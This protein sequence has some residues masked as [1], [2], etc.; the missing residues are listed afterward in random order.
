[1]STLLLEG[2]AEF[3]GRMSEPDLQALQLAGGLAAPIAILPTAAAPDH[4][5]ERAGR[6]GWRWFSS[7]GASS[8]DVVPVVD[9]ATAEDPALAARLRSARLIYILGGFPGFLARTLSGS[10]AWQACLDAYAGGAVLAGSSAGA[11]VLCQY[12]YDPE[13]GQTMPGLNL[14]SNACVLPHHNTFGRGWA[15]RL[16]KALPHVLLI[17]IDEQTGM[18]GDPAGSWTVW[19]AGQVTLYRGSEVATLPLRR[20]L[21]AGGQSIASAPPSVLEA[22]SDPPARITDHGTL[23]PIVFCPIMLYKGLPWHLSSGSMRCRF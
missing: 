17:G 11:M 23:L 18:L 14:I 20:P 5:D 10:R 7:L 8:L 19:G 4:N 15:P 9:K 12:V 13:Q 16:Q 22:A 3:G 1:M 6:N 2:G 21:Y